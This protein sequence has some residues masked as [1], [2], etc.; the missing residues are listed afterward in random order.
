MLAA[1]LPED[2]F[3]C[4]GFQVAEQVVGIICKYVVTA[5]KYRAQP[6]EGILPPI[7]LAVPMML[8]PIVRRLF[9]RFEGI[10]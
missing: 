9:T 10:L 3:P 8:L 6:Y 5:S 4:L 2:T 7:L 1:R